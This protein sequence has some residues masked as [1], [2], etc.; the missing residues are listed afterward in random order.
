[1]KKLRNVGTSFTNPE[2]CKSKKTTEA[3]LWDF[4]GHEFVAS[5]QI[6]LN[7]N[8]RSRRVTEIVTQ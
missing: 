6:Y 2:V 3:N 4:L 7:R 8:L 5:T 1:M